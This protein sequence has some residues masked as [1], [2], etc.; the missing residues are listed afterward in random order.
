MSGLVNL[1]GSCRFRVAEL[2]KV[3]HECS[4]VILARNETLNCLHIGFSP[5]VPTLVQIFVNLT[6]QGKNTGV[7]AVVFSVALALVVPLL[8]I[9]VNAGGDERR[10][11]V[12]MPLLL[13]KVK[14]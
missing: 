7:Y 4:S 2:F 9:N 12:A 14:S 8:W 6:A 3:R 5:F 1:P 10:F 11:P 13:K